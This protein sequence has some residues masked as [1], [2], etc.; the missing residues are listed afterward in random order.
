[1]PD[2]A[3]TYSGE[4]RFPCPLQNIHRYFFWLWIPVLA[5]LWWDALLAFRFPDGFGI[6]VGTLVLLLNAALLSLYSLS[7]HSCRHICGGHHDLFSKVP[8]AYRL[9]RRIT[10][11]NERTCYRV[12]EPGVV[13]P[14]DLYVRLVSMGVISDL[15]F[16]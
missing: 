16:F 1:M 7:C 6:G 10:Q 5:F 13:G 3:K 9:W 11:L 12:G 2:R 15:R 4:T 14:T 8:G